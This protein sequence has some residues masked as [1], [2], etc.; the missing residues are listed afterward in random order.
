MYSFDLN[1]ALHRK[2]HETINK[3]VI[4]K[5]TQLYV[6]EM[7]AFSMFKYMYNMYNV[8]Y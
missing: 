6:L 8:C 4:I 5:K 3:V 7:N 2:G 1:K